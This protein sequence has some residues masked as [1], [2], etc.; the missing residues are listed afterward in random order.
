MQ[1]R[2]LFILIMNN[3]ICFVFKQKVKSMVYVTSGAFATFSAISL[4]R[5]DEK[6]Y[7]NILMPL[8]HKL[9]PETSH[10]IA[11]LASKYG[12][13]PRSRYEDPV[14]LVRFRLN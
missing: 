14:T 11:I 8:V 5:G 12:L 3:D 13:I 1:G 7:D 2:D 9:N 4:Y 10:N 6:Y